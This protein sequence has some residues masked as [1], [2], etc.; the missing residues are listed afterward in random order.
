MLDLGIDID[1]WPW[2]WLSV[3]VIFFVVEFTAL[4]GSFV[5][6]PFAVSA[7][8]ASIAGFYDASVELQWVIFLLL[9]AILWVLAFR[10]ARRWIHDELPLGVGA[11]RVIGLS[12]IVTRTIDPDDTDRKGR[13]SVDG[14]VWGAITRSDDIV[15]QGVRVKIVEVLGT[16]VVV[17]PISLPTQQNQGMS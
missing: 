12:G 5:L 3:S 8:V 14:E 16:R 7:F 1:A 11:D 15:Q 13:V 9:G 6:L 17:E 4:A 2:I 10:F